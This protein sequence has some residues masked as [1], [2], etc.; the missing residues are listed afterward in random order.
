MKK[1]V[2]LLLISIKD[3]LKINH[4]DGFSFSISCLVLEILVFCNILLKLICDVIYSRIRNEIF[5]TKNISR[6]NWQDST[7]F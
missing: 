3:R 4:Q 1:I 7:N 5:R 6:S 2:C